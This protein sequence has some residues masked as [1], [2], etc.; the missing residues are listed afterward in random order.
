MCADHFE[1][2]GTSDLDTDYDNNFA[3]RISAYVAN[4]HKTCLYHP[5]GVFMESL[6]N[7]EV[8]NV[9]LSLKSGISGVSL[10][11]EH[12]RFAE[13]PLWHLLHELY[14]HFFLNFSVS[15]SLKTG[16]ILPLFKGKGAKANNMDQFSSSEGVGC[17]EVSFT[18]LETINHMLE[19]GSEVFSCF[20]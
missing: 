14:N 3:T 16:L 13:P 19:H 1:E 5:V 2:L 9:C 17:I 12:I 11:Y 6:S 18:I 10:D 4:F 7:E 8:A 15:K 20:A